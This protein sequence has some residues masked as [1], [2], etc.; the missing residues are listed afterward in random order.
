M[1][2]YRLSCVD[3]QRHK[4]YTAAYIHGNAENFF[5]F[6][7][8]FSRSPTRFQSHSLCS[9]PQP[10]CAQDTSYLTTLPSSPDINPHRCTGAAC[11]DP[12]AQRDAA[13]STARPM[14]TYNA[15]SQTIPILRPKTR[16]IKALLLVSE[17]YF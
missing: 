16:N 7:F 13:Y 9:L 1:L 3:V 6:S 8:F 4:L 5:S 2:R 17:V 10:N 14:L 12:R 15:F 11:G